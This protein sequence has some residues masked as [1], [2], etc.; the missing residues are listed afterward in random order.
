MK[1]KDL[2]QI[3]KEEYFAILNESFNDPLITKLNKMADL[4]TKWKNFWSSAAKTYDIAWDKLPKGSF[5]VVPTT[6]S[7]IKKGMAFYV[8]NQDKKN[9]YAQDSWDNTLRGPAVL[10][11]T[12]D[13]KIQY[14]GRNEVYGNKG[15]GIGTKDDKKTFRHNPDPV[16]KGTRGTLQTSKLKTLA[17]EIYLFDL[18]SYRGGTS[19]LK[20]TRAA[21]KLGKDKFTDAKSWKAANL[22]RY[23]E[24]LNARVGSKDQVD[25]MVAKIVQICNEIV[26]EA[27]ALPKLGQYGYLM[28]TVQGKQVKLEDV[29]KGMT[30]ALEY[31][32]QYIEMTGGYENAKKA[33]QD[34]F[35]G[36][37]SYYKNRIS[38]K[39]GEIKSILLKLT[40]GKIDGWW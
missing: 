22:Q 14:Y 13:N 9:P 35:T 33:D 18:E 2:R 20:S 25:S 4:N 40:S 36:D 31:Y 39:A 30:R 26:S 19:A 21:L 7:E 11:V 27:M 32:G 1:L 34:G 8:I 17:D 37:I 10:A 3:I 6:S 12:I 5:R 24:I 16:G 15:G 38:D 29:T 23:K 28:A